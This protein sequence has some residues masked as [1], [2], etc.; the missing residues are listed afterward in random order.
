[1][2]DRALANLALA[3]LSADANADQAETRRGTPILGTQTWGYIH[4]WD[5]TGS[6]IIWYL[7]GSGPPYDD[8]ANNTEIGS[9]YRP[10]TGRFKNTGT[11]IFWYRAGSAPEYLFTD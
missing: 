2:A 4:F 3:F 11:D 7:E 5:T 1:M 8:P 6:D 9:G 10:I